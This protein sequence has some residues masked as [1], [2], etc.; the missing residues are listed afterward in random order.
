MKFKQVNYMK[1]PGLFHCFWNNIAVNGNT[2]TKLSL[3][4]N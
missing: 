3:N 1:Q 4:H 2:L